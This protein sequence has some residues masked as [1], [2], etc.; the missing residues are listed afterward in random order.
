MAH[1]CILHP[2]FNQM[3]SASAPL[4]WSPGVL[5]GLLLVLAGPVLVLGFGL[6]VL[7]EA[8]L[9]LVEALLV[10]DEA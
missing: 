5:A 1:L 10:L 2:C 7:F 8:S 3:K 6:V 9:V 4:S